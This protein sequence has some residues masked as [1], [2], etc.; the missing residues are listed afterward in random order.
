[1][2]WAA[3]HIVRGL[4]QRGVSA[5]LKGE[6][7]SKK[8]EWS[9]S[10]QGSFSHTLLGLWGFKLFA[11]AGQNL[12]MMMMMMVMLLMT[13]VGR[14]RLWNAGENGE[15]RKRIGMG[16][17]VVSRGFLL[18]FF[19][20]LV[21]TVCKWLHCG[22]LFCCMGGKGNPEVC[23]ITRIQGNNTISYGINT[24]HCE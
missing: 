23:F 18:F 19:V 3:I 4:N 5:C 8:K 17:D 22:Q 10:V 24:A 20:V 21:C 2:P 16:K 11:S 15:G 14:R 12:K 7:F 13:L 9:S 1:M 6:G